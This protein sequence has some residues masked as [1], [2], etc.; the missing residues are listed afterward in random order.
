[1]AGDIEMFRDLYPE[2]IYWTDLEFQRAKLAFLQNNSDDEDFQEDSAQAYFDG[3]AKDAKRIR[4]GISIVPWPE[5]NYKMLNRIREQTLEICLIKIAQISRISVVQAKLSTTLKALSITREEWLMQVVRN[6]EVNGIT[7][8]ED[9]FR[10]IQA[11]IPNWEDQFLNIPAKRILAAPNWQKPFD[12]VNAGLSEFNFPVLDTYLEQMHNRIARGHGWLGVGEWNVA[13]RHYLNALTIAISTNNID[14]IEAITRFLVDSYVASKNLRSAINIA[15]DFLN[16]QAYRKTNLNYMTRQLLES[17]VIG[18]AMEGNTPAC[19][20]WLSKIPT[21]C[22][23][24]SETEIRDWNICLL[25]ISIHTWKNNK[26]GFME[27]DR[28]I[29]AVSKLF[30]N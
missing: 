29:T 26:I 23:T 11:G 1:M 13:N 4:N 7:M 3:L 25:L 16:S 18:L 6:A 27:L 20:E 9:E 10:Y 8:S 15:N 24:R 12:A 22:E 28:A 14:A 19:K 17:I 30:A 5:A 2:V 21:L